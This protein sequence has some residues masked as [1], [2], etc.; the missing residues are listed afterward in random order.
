MATIRDAGIT[1]DFVHEPLQDPGNEIRLIQVTLSGDRDDE[2]Q[3]T[4]TPYAV[5]K[6]PP[7]VA[8]SYTWGDISCGRHVRVNGKQLY[9]GQNSWMVLWQARLHQLASPLWMDV[10]SIDQASD[11]EKS[12]QVGMM[13]RIYKT[14]MYTF[15]SLGSHDNDSRFLAEQIQAHIDFVKHR[16]IQ[17]T[18]LYA[19]GC[20]ACGGRITDWCEGARK[21]DGVEHSVLDHP[22]PEFRFEC[23]CVECGQT[24]SPKFYELRQNAEHRFSMVCSNCA[25]AHLEGTDS[26][27]WRAR[28]VLTDEL[29]S[30]SRTDVE[31]LQDRL[32]TSARLYDLDQETHQRIFDALSALSLRAYFTRL[33]I[34][35]EVRQ[36]HSVLIACGDS[37]FGFLEL[38]V[39]SHDLFLEPQTDIHQQ[40][41]TNLDRRDLSWYMQVFLSW[42]DG[43]VVEESNIWSLVDTFKSSRCYDPRDRVFGLLALVHPDSPTRL[44]PDYTKSVTEVVLELVESKAEHDAQTAA[45]FS[46]T[47]D[48][49]PSYVHR[50]YEFNFFQAFGLIRDFYLSSD[51]L[52]NALNHTRPGAGYRD[53]Y[54]HLNSSVPSDDSQY[55]IMIADSS[56]RIRRNDSGQCVVPLVRTGASTGDFRIDQ[57]YQEDAIK[58]RS[59]TETVL[60]F[61]DS[62][63]EPGDILLFL[64]DDTEV[65][66]APVPGLV[67]RPF[68]HDMYSVVGQFICDDGVKL[69]PGVNNQDEILNLE[70]PSHLQPDKALSSTNG[71]D[72]GNKKFYT[73]ATCSGECQC[74]S[75]QSLHSLDGGTWKVRMSPEDLLLFVAQ[76]LKT[77]PMNDPLDKSEELVVNCAVGSVEVARRLATK[78]ASDMFSSYATREEWQV[79]KEFQRSN[80]DDEIPEFVPSWR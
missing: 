53:V 56:C 42:M 61:A 5:N 35:Q 79:H 69:C 73:T 21:H 70:S 43:S 59:P 54:E 71:S 40:R 63:T 33:W 12:I 14:A 13:G 16:R 8:V 27:L 3:C 47:I 48:A 57:E 2:I 74:G 25:Q 65:W 19:L 80:M 4:I 68:K 10:L 38:G 55:F 45:V 72:G 64:Q 6:A 49:H 51:P 39:I 44:R 46:R 36:A 78:V 24:L 26:E 77:Q 9:I 15:V 32:Q 67:V 23:G 18:E 50:A 66:A 17:D 22:R 7:Y 1:G 58:L 60:A 28:Y 34:I 62:K 31:V 41:W 52:Q 75:G 20:S 30:M 11:V 29:K 76:D 37:L